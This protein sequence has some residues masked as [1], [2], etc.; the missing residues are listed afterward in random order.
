MQLLCQTPC[1]FWGEGG[2]RVAAVSSYGGLGG[3]DQSRVVFL[4]DRRRPRRL[5]QGKYAVCDV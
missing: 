3:I 1:C 2:E 5:A 4:V